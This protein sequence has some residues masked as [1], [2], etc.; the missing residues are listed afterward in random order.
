[1][2]TILFTLRHGSLFGSVDYSGPIIVQGGY[3]PYGRVYKTQEE[4]ET[5][6]AAG[7]QFNKAKTGELLTG[8]NG[9]AALLNFHENKLVTDEGVEAAEEGHEAFH[10]CY[11][12]PQP[13]FNPAKGEEGIRGSLQK[14]T[15]MNNQTVQ[16]Y[17]P[18]TGVGPRPNGPDIHPTPAGYKKLAQIMTAACG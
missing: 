17:P 13:T 18:V 9:L 16:T 2:G 4:V 14:F 12:N 8:S 5:A 1:V 10:A 6:K 3:D 15:N 7:P 11:A